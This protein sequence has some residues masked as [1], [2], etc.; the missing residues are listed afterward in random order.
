MQP[1]SRRLELLHGLAGHKPGA[2]KGSGPGSAK[3]PGAADMSS[4]R[5][6]VD[7]SSSAGWRSGA[8][9]LFLGNHSFVNAY[10]AMPDPR[11]TSAIGA[12]LGPRKEGL[13][14]ARSSLCYLTFRAATGRVADSLRTESMLSLGT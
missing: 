8:A 9:T 3:A 5:R 11:I 6:A 7:G 14:S 1:P 4:W 13:T 10:I 2:V 12:A